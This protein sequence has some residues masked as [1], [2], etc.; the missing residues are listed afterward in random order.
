MGDSLPYLLGRAALKVNMAPHCM[1]AALFGRHYL[2]LWS[3]NFTHSLLTPCYCDTGLNFINQPSYLLESLLE[4]AKKP[5]DLSKDR[6][7][8]FFTLCSKY[9]RFVNFCEQNFTKRLRGCLKNRACCTRLRAK[10][11]SSTL[12]LRDKREIH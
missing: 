12:L 6:P 3:F 10:R 5:G 4:R 7:L 8:G 2:S 1:Y 11:E 9:D